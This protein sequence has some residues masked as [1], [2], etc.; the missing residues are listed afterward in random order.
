MKA[1]VVGIATQ[2]YTEIKYGRE[3]PI[4]LEGD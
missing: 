4:L 3:G 1:K 2:G